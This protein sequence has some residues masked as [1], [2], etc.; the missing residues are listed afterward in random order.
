MGR[1]GE[2]TPE[3]LPVSWQQEGQALLSPVWQGPGPQQEILHIGA[4]T[5]EPEERKPPEGSLRCVWPVCPHCPGWL[6][7]LCPPEHRASAAETGAHPAPLAL[8][9]FVPLPPHQPN[10]S[11]LERSRL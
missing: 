8:Y 11:T 3:G 9:G 7:V 6:E 1:E 4:L 5:E 2:V 10:S